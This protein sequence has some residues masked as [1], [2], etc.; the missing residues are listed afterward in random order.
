MIT[1]MLIASFQTASSLTFALYQL[2]RNQHV[3]DK[4]YADIDK[5]LP[6]DR[7]LTESALKKMSYVKA[8]VKESLRYTFPIPGP[9]DRKIVE[10]V[11][12]KGFLIPKGVCKLEH[13]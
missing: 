6:D 9:L 13:A 5:H 4:L 1:D 12:I 7:V 10:D 3:Q 8:C 2:A 11:A